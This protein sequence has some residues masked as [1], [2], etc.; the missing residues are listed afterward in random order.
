MAPKLQI[1][2]VEDMYVLY[3]LNAKIDATTFWHEPIASVERIYSG[4]LA[5]DGWSNSPKEVK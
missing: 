2:T 1:E 3:V 5:F 4:K